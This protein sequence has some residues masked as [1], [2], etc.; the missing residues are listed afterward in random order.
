MDWI[1]RRLRKLE[2]VTSR[3]RG[4]AARDNVAE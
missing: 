1:S 3:N 4:Q 2:A